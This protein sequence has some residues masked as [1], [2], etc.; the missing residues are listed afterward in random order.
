[1]P[2]R[3]LIALLVL[4]PTGLLT[5][6]V[7][8]QQTAAPA[9]A[10]T[11]ATPTPQG[12]HTENGLAGFAKISVRRVRLRARSGR[13]REEQRLFLHARGRAELGEVDRRS[14]YKSVKASFGDDDARGAVL[15]RSGLHHPDRRTSPASTSRRSPVKTTLPDA[16]TQ[17][18]PMGDRAGHDAAA[19]RASI[20]AKLDAAVDAAFADPGGADRRAS[21]SSTRAGSS[22]SA[23]CPAS[24]RTRSS[25]AGRWARASRRRC[26]RCSSR[27]APTRSSSRRRCR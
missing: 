11:A 22:P 21:S 20:S 7:A 15:R 23:T 1:M 8:A 27:T 9:P 10:Q 13:R 25:R 4:A 14:V 26:S 19:R 3:L 16:T 24:P 12:T 17:P 18:W 2:R 5:L 6:H